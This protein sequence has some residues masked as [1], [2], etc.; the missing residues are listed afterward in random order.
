[1]S[2]EVAVE[3]EVNAPPRPRAPPIV[4]APETEEEA[5]ETKPPYSVERPEM[6]RV[7]EAPILFVTR[8]MWYS[9]E[10]VL[11]PLN[12]VV[13]VAMYAAIEVVEKPLNWKPLLFAK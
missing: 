11:N 13:V 10:V 4:N 8:P 7:D 5:V 2:V 6:A 1:M 12:W 3:D 9:A